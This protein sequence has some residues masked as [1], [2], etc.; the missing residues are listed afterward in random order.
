MDKYDD[1]LIQND[2]NG[3]S[4]I[5]NALRMDK[6]FNCIDEFYDF[7]EGIIQFIQK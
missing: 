3:F 7:H 4:V 5:I 1:F 6:Y 2:K